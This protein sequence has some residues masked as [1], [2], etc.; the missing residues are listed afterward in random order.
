MNSLVVG[1][2]HSITIEA[3][4]NKENQ[5]QNDQTISLESYLIENRSNFYFLDLFVN[6]D[7]V[8]IIGL[9]YLIVKG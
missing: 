2:N 5:S 6:I 1:S 8:I 7:I 9:I 3:A 4:T